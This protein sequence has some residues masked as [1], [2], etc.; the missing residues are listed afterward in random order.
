MFDGLGSIGVIVAAR[1]GSSRLPGKVLRPLGGVPM[2]LFLLSR[3]AA[4]RSVT[5]IVLATTDLVAD[6]DLTRVVEDAGYP[7]FRGEQ[8]DVV[9]RYVNA[10]RHYA[11]DHVVRVTG[12]CP[13]VDAETLDYCVRQAA[14]RSPFDLATTKGCFPVGI[15]FEIYPA[16]LMAQLD[17]SGLLDA[18]EREHL[19]L[20]LYDTPNDYKVIK[21]EPLP[22]WRTSAHFTVDTE[23]DYARVEALVSV[24]GCNDFSIADLVS[25]AG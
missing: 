16:P 21:L 15:D 25:R 23:A 5:Q 14:Q 1:T 9:R 22:A 20:H 6:N 18:S 2:I 7:V 10:A 12:D 19:T 24:L 11:F 17:H 13:F 8:N 4:A 3:L